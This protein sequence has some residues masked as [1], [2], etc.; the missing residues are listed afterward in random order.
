MGTEG[1][2]RLFSL[3]LVRFEIDPSEWTDEPF[4]AGLLTRARS[5]LFPEVIE[6]SLDLRLGESEAVAPIEQASVRIAVE[7]GYE[8][9]ESARIVRPEQLAASLDLGELADRLGKAL[10]VAEGSASE[11]RQQYA[12]EAAK[13]LTADLAP[14]MGFL[15]GQIKRGDGDVESARLALRQRRMLLDNLTRSRSEVA[16]AAIVFGV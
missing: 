1:R 9:S 3:V 14:E 2:G 11:E 8:G 16:G 6:R 10:K 5:Y 7:A 12:H 15:A 13:A 4:D